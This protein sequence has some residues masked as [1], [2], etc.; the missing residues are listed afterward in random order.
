MKQVSTT[1]VWNDE[2]LLKDSFDEPTVSEPGT[3]FQYINTNPVVLGAIIKKI[4]G[5]PWDV[6]VHRRISIPLGLGSVTNPA[7]ANHVAPAAKPY[8]RWGPISASDIYSNTLY[9]AAGALFGNIADLHTWGCALGSGL[10]LPP[11]LNAQRRV[12]ASS[13]LGSGS[14]GYAYN[15]DGLAIGKNNGWVGHVGFGLGYEGSPCTTQKMP[16]QFQFCSTVTV[17]GFCEL[18]NFSG[19]SSKSDSVRAAYGLLLLS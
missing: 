9:S 1:F 6:E 14:I 18:C 4:T 3:T 19:N 13:G 12:F 7:D 8:D 10:L 2:L 16:P 15:S 17:Q 11:Y 5:N